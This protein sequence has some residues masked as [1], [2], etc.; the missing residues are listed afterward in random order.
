M[1]QEMSLYSKACQIQN[2]PTVVTFKDNSLS[3]PVCVLP[4]LPHPPH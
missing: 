3:F 2:D 1:G 4:E